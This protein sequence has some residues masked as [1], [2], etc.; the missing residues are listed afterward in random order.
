[1][2]WNTSCGVIWEFNNGG[3]AENMAHF[4]H[5]CGGVLLPSPFEDDPT[6]REKLPA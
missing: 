6:T 4:C 5:H 2:T 1:M 3:P